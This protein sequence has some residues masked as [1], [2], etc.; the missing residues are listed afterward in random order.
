MKDITA[1]NIAIT[2]VAA[3]LITMAFLL[4]DVWG[5]SYDLE[6]KFNAV[7]LQYDT[8]IFVTKPMSG[9]GPTT[10]DSV[11]ATT[12]PFVDTLS[13]N[14]DTLY[15]VQVYY[16]FENIN[17]L[18]YAEA[19]Y[20]APGTPPAA[21]CIGSGSDTLIYYT[22]DTGNDVRVEAAQVSLYAI[23][24]SAVSPKQLTDGNGYVLVA[25]NSGDTI[26]AIV[27]GPHTYNWE[28]DTVV[29]TGQTSDSA[30][31]WKTTDPAAA[32][33]PSYVNVYFDVGAAYIDSTTGLMVTRE[34]VDIYCELIGGKYL[35]G[36]TW[37]LLPQIPP[38]R[39]DTAGR[40]QFLLPAN[41]KIMPAGS[42]YQLSWRARDGYNILGDVLR[43][44][45]IDTLPDP[46]NIWEATEVH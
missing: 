21:S 27:Y 31:G 46:I 32:S 29:F 13:L 34:K 3:F 24:G 16:S 12:F 40:V 26:L 45:I 25:L 20:L 22:V 30:V 4:S 19:Y 6:L 1:R 43:K 17:G 39:P 7:P 2:A 44:F 36:T 10:R 28:L 37:A 35:T 18:T 42:Y 38:K 9:S 8:V 41:T 14:S 11:F 15:Q 23:G 33:T 5:A